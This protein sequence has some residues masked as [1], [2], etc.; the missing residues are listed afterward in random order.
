MSKETKF[1]V[2]C[3]AQID[4]KEEICPGCGVKQPLLPRAPQ[5]YMIGKKS[6]TLAAVLSFLITGL[7]QI[8]VG[9]I[10]RGLAFLIFGFLVAGVAS[11]AYGGG[12]VWIIAIIIWGAAAYDAYTLAQKYNRHIE[13]HGETP[14]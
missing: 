14:W 1:C 4:I 2:N 9:Q 10:T 11:L 13:I 8:Y 5:A 6:P 7:G 3:G 12:I